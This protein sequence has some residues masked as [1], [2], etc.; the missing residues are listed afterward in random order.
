MLGRMDYGPFGQEL[1]PS[2]GKTVEI[3]A[4]EAA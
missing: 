4:R 3:D 1:V 2:T